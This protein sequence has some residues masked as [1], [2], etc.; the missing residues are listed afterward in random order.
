MQCLSICVATNMFFLQLR[1]M[2]YRNTISPVSSIKRHL[3]AILAYFPLQFQLIIIIIYPYS[4]QR[5]RYD[6]ITANWCTPRPHHVCPH[7]H[8]Q[9]CLFLSLSNG[10]ELFR[11]NLQKM[12]GRPA[13]TYQEMVHLY[14]AIIGK[15]IKKLSSSSTATR[16]F[17]FAP[18]FWI[19]LLEVWTL[20]FVH[21]IQATSVKVCKQ[22]ILC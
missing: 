4:Q 19:W 3:S 13:K 12:F 11:D 1:C 17:K 2:I 8:K 18:N 6:S 22:H 15:I 21:C 20:F 5:L 7:Q 16:V 9:F 10:I 14:A